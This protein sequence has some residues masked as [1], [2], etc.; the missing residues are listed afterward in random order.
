MTTT[1]YAKLENNLLTRYHQPIHTDSGDIFTNEPDV[2][3]RYGYFPL[4]CTPAPEVDEHHYPVFH[5][6]LTNN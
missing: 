5:W 2:L 6:E 4:I 1:I 3:A